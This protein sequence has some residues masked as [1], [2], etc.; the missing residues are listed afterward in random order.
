MARP[1]AS[2]NVTCQNP[3][4][5]FFGKERGKDIIRRGV[6]RPGH[7]L[8][9]CLHCNH[10]FVETILTPLY[11]KHLPEKEIIGICKLLVEKNGIRSIERITGHHRDTIGNLL[12]DMAEHAEYVN[13][14][15]LKSIPLEEY[16]M[17]EL[18]TIVKKNRK[19]LSVTARMHLKRVMRGSTQQ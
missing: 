15:L 13:E 11:R 16:E 5:R 17:D 8:Y 4:C 12:E 6:N 7:Q 3:K 19:K 14:T 1:R 9:R 18:W 10:T 2:N